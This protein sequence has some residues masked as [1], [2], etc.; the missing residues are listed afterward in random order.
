MQPAA[1][2]AS[3]AL[4]DAGIAVAHRMIDADVRSSRSRSASRLALR[5]DRERRA[6][7]GPHLA[8]GFRRLSR[9]GAQDDAVQDRLPRDCGD[10]DDA[11]VAEEFGEI[12]P[13][14]ARLGRVGRAEVDQQHADLRL[15]M[16]DGRRA[17]CVA[18]GSNGRSRMRL[19]VPAIDGVGDGGGERRVPRPLIPPGWSLLGMI[20]TAICGRRRPRQAECRRS[21]A[22]AACRRPIRAGPRSLGPSP[23]SVRFDLLRRPAR[24]LTTRPQSTAATRRSTFTR[25]VVADA[26][27]RDQRRCASR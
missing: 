18:I 17:S 11:R 14:R 22:R 3:I 16:S 21:P 7:V 15:G 2:F 4:G 24:E 26:R 19:P 6:F 5:D 20:S 12:A 25:L 8:I 9:P 23:R 10:F 13:D 1:P 27:G